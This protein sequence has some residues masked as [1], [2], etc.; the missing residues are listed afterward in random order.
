VRVPSARL[1]RGDVGGVVVGKEQRRAAAPAAFFDDFVDARI[2][3]GDLFNPGDDDV[4]EQIEDR[5]LAPERREQLG[6]EIGQAEQWYPARA[7][8]PRQIVHAWDLPRQ[9]LVEA[10]GIGRNQQRLIRELC[11]PFG[12]HNA[13]RFAPVMAEMPFLGHDMAEEPRPF[14]GIVD[15]LFEQATEL[16]MKQY[17]PDIEDHRF[18]H[19]ACS[20]KASGPHSD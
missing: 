15:Q 8:P 13:Q 4:L 1:C 18:L 6:P 5:L 12:Q 20:S 7:Q 3:L 11:D 10:R 16:P 9:G 17:P 14:I 2:G 19:V